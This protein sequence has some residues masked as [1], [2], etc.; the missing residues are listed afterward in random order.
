MVQAGFLI[1]I[2]SKYHL[3][4]I[5][6]FIYLLMD[7]IKSNCPINCINWPIFSSWHVFFTYS[8]GMD[9]SIYTIVPWDPLTLKTKSTGVAEK[10]L[11]VS[12]NTCRNFVIEVE[13]SGPPPF[14]PIL[15]VWVQ[16]WTYMKQQSKGAGRLR[17]WEFSTQDTHGMF[18]P[19]HY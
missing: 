4:G 10:T 5:D 6:N 16:H 17:C 2:N 9:P 18:Q 3:H 15:V 14:P 12:G 11:D 1:T 19:I 13:V 8:W 7:P